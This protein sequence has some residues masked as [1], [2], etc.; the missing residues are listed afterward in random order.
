L[1]NRAVN[2]SDK[3]IE[4]GIDEKNNPNFPILTS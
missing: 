1:V 2:S 4:G 3:M